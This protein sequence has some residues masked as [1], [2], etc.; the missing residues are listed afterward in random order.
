[1]AGMNWDGSTLEARLLA[2][3]AVLNWRELN[4]TRH[5]AADG[6]V[7]NVR[8]RMAIDQGRE[9]TRKM[10]ETTLQEQA[11]EVEQS[12]LSASL[13][14]TGHRPGRAPAE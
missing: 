9:F 5:V 10:I 3:Q 8:E 2:E 6:T 7:L 11:C 4:K 14:N 1:M 12:S 13:P